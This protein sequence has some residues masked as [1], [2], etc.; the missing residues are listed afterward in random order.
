MKNALRTILPAVLLM[1]FLSGSALAQTK[2]A[3]V[4][5]RKLFDGYWKTKEAQADIQEQKAQLDK[6]DNALRDGYKKISDEY[7]QLV[8]RA[9]DQV[10]S[11]D[12]RARRQQAAADK[13]KQLQESNAQIDSYE[14]EAQTRLSDQ[15][16][17]TRDKV[18]ADIKEHIDAAAK[19]GGYS[20]VLDTDAKSATA[21]DIVLYHDV[22]NDLT[23]A[24]LKQLNAGS[25]ID[26]TAPAMTTPAPSL[27]DTN[28]P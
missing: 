6:D 14:H 3:T 10:I 16:Q 19:A 23:D 2:I 4:N 11:A 22:E 7:Q 24:V 8:A 1:T 13:L 9:N 26:T 5:L 28:S 15:L 21:T 20:L 17:R 25:P 12:E 18:L 27:L